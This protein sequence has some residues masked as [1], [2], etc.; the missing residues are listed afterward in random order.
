VWTTQP[1]NDTIDSIS[2]KIREFAAEMFDAK[3][4]KYN[5]EIDESLLDCKLPPNQVYNFYLIIK[6]A[7]NNIAKYAQAKNVV[8][9]ISKSEDLLKLLIKDDGIGFDHST[10]KETGNGLKNMD[11][12][13]QDLEGKLTIN[14]K[15][16]E[17]TELILE[18]PIHG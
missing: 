9:N 14:S 11:R 12:R 2:I 1:V 13:S 4:I 7:I 3:D 8:V 17:G 15:P 5:I 6:E 10:I 18:F 16:N